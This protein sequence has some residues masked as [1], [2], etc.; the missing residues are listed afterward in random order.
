[1]GVIVDNP[2]PLRNC[3]T[4]PVWQKRHGQVYLVFIDE[5]FLQ[6]FELNSRGYFCHAAV[7]IPEAEYGALTKEIEP[8]FDRYRALLVPEVKEFK[9][10]DFKRIAF[11][12]RSL[13]A[14]RLR[15][16]LHTHGV[17][18][19]GFYTPAN[20]YLLERIRVD[21]LMKGECVFRPS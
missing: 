9:H 8:I 17:F 16:L 20:A 15:D 3:P 5:S 19:S 4:L 18:I 21:L 12:D 6:F 11:S 7:G 2:Q 14:A 10:T 13:I 1:M